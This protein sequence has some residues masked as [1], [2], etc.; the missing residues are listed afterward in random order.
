MNWTGKRVLVTGAG[1]FIGSHLAERLTE[2]G[3]R[4]RALVRYTSNGNWGWL[5][6]SPRKGDMEVM[7]GDIRDRD[8]VREAMRDIDQVFHLAARIA[9]PYSYHAPDSYV[10]TNVAGTLNV[11]QAA[12]DVGAERVVHTSTSEVYGTARYVPIDEKHPLQGQ[13]PYS[14]SKIGADKMAEAFHL[15]FGLPVV[16]VKPFNTYGPRQSARAVIPTIVTQC[17][18]GQRTIRL[19]NLDPTRDL[20]HVADTVEGFLAAAASPQA[21]GQV[22]NLGNGKEISIGDLARRIAQLAGADIAIEC[23]EQRVRPAGS[24]VERLLADNGQMKALTGW[25]PQVSLDK[26]LRDTIAWIEANR[27]AFRPHIYQV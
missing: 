10:Q 14:A 5:D 23:D 7:L 13:S 27:G 1:G 8:S 3:A 6:S 15:S 19:G 12:R 9:I 25:Q 20:S 11:L 26:G 18:A 17:L 16:T 22:L 2:L 4:T 24:E 21:I